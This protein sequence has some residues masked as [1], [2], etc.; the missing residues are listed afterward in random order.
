MRKGYYNQ[1][2]DKLLKNFDKTVSP[3]K[4]RL[5]TR[6]SQGFIDTLAQDARKEYEK[7]IPDIPYT[8]KILIGELIILN[9]ETT[10]S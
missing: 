8:A 10:T 6:Y 2:K 4:E 1:K 9:V 5:A 3:T 7:I